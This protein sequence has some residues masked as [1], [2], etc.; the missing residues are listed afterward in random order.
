M[1]RSNN[2]IADV[3][4]PTPLEPSRPA[5]LPAK[6]DN[7]PDDKPANKPDK[8]SDQVPGRL[9]EHEAAP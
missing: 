3:P 4:P 1:K 5:R 9:A 2:L 7:E 8:S 6:S